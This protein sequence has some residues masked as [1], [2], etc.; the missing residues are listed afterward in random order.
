MRRKS[1]NRAIALLIMTTLFTVTGCAVPGSV[2]TDNGSTS[3]SVQES[4]VASAEN[5]GDDGQQLANPWEDISQDEAMK[6]T[7]RLFVIPQGATNVAW[8]MMKEEGSD[9]P[10][11]QASFELD[12]KE[13]TARTQYGVDENK[14]ISGMN[15]EWTNTEEGHIGWYDG[16]MSAKFYRYVG[17]ESAD[18]CTWYDTEIGIAY[19]LSTVA[20]DLDGFDIAAVADMMA[21][22][23]DVMLE[24]F[25]QAKAGKE[26]FE[27]YDEVISYLEKDQGYAYIKV[28]GY[29]GD[30][31]LVTDY[32]YEN[33]PK[34]KAS[35]Q[36]AVY[37]K[38]GDTVRSAG[39]VATAGTAYPLAVADGLLYSCNPHSYEVQFFNPD[40]YGLMYKDDVYEEYDSDGKA[41][42]GG[43]TRETNSFEVTEDFNGGE[44]E[45]KALW[46][47]YFAA[48]V[49]NFTVVE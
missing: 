30:V 35:I 36:A 39:W 18:L 42:Y 3:V 38:D 7:V 37:I 4:S 29:E 21:P 8:S 32:V 6:N 19:S 46:D 28:K 12:G 24:D 45:Y 20:K 40:G 17:D 16:N 48:E 26:T 34:T 9:S 49:I 10:L 11:I 1:A 33:D 27:S 14:D 31:L 41:T 15:Y 5:S 25:V 44:A 23:E 43:F 13:F 47:N 22:E 2:T